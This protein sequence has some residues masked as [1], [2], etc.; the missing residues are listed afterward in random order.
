MSPASYVNPVVRKL[1]REVGIRMTE[2]TPRV[3]T[4]EVVPHA[5][6][7][8]TF[9]CLDRCPIG[10]Q[11]KGEDWPIPGA[12]EKSVPQLREVRNEP[13]KRIDDL[14]LR[15]CVPAKTVPS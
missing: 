7:V 8:V 11:G 9:G 4:R 6:K 2:K 10:A 12:T 15:F 3:V 5:S 1:L 14:I 13:S